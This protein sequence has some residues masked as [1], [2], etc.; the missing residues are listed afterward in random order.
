M[1]NQS[2]LLRDTDD[3]DGVPLAAAEQHG[4]RWF[5]IAKLEALLALLVTDLQ[6]FTPLVQRLG[7]REAQRVIRLHNQLLRD[8]LA[9]LGGAEIAHTGDGILA[10]FRSVNCALRCAAEMQRRLERHTRQHPEAPLR[11]RIGV[12]AGEPLPE[13]GR[14]FGTCVIT[15]VRICSVTQPEHVLVSDVVRQLAVG[16]AVE[17]TDRGMFPLKGFEA[18]LH[19]HELIWCSIAERDAHTV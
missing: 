4:A 1:S 6:G 18:P 11:A 19:L 15:A 2:Y 3:E 14:L 17:F 10:A 5:E 8:C 16:K 12:H 9:A 7:D 13:D